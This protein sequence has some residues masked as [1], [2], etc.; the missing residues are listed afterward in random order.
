M[1][2]E[3]RRWLLSGGIGSGKTEVGR[4]LAATGIRVLDADRIG[5]RVLEPAGKAFSAVANRWP[6]VVRDGVID[7]GRLAG[8]VF[9]DPG[10][11][12]ELESL[13]HPH[14]FGTIQ[15][16]LERFEGLAVVEVP[17]L[18]AGLAWPRLVVDAPDQIRFERA[19]ER[20]MSTDD[21]RAR[22]ASQPSRGQWLAS[23]DLVI[24]NF[25]T[26]EE[27][28]ETI[29]DLVPDLSPHERSDV[30]GIPGEAED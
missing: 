22:M 10:Q 15:D 12:R 5:H 7:R 19:L 9:A 28:K 4:L 6:E 26:L 13:T 30:G 24:P 16:E 2:S 11:L 3:N 14:I 23:A 18:E 8:I 17:I 27:L 1:T 20:G 29:V 21:I 25:G